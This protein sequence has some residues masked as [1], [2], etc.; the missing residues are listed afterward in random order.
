MGVQSQKPKEPPS[1][2][3]SRH[4][5][6]GSECCE[7]Q[8]GDNALRHRLQRVKAKIAV[9][10]FFSDMPRYLD[11]FSSEWRSRR[12]EQL[13]SC[14]GTCENYCDRNTK[15]IGTLI[16]VPLAALL[17]ATAHVP[18]FA[19]L[20]ALYFGY[21]C[22]LSTLSTVVLLP[23]LLMIIPLFTTEPCFFVVM[24]AGPRPRCACVP[25]TSLTEMT[26][27]HSRC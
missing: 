10:K 23:C 21:Q 14:L 19:Q 13:F 4:A 20:P 8:S 12:W 27:R 6:G 25:D 18:I 24:L 2:A 9:F 5:A 1:P 11:R 22:S 15:Q 17:L 3:G 26:T 7:S 16:Y